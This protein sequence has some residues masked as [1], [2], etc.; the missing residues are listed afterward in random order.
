MSEEV[1]LLLRR[2]SGGDASALEA[3]A[4]LVY[5]ELRRLAHRQLARERDDHTLQST[6]LVN[7]A[8]LRL[9][10]GPEVEWQDR[11]H[12]YAVSSQMIR[13]ILVDHARQRHAGKRG[14]GA[15]M[16]ELNEELM[17]GA[18]RAVELI[19]LDDALSG[20]A[21]LD[22]VQSQVVEMR[23]FGGLSTEEIACALGIAPRTVG[24]YW[25]SARLWLLREMSR[26]EKK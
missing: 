15:A 1:T 10:R 3:L 21:K 14:A 16:V 7:E 8:F 2:W 12:F 4:P 18:P 9:I 6:A 19:A 24:R 5:A 11:A 17:P 26:V 13:R 20:L 23:F 22:P 25:A